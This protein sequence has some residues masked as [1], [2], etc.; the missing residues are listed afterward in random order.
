MADEVQREIVGD[1][2]FR[3]RDVNEAVAK[4]REFSWSDGAE[5]H[6][7]LS[8]DLDK[9]SAAAFRESVEPVAVAACRAGG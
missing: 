1:D 2:R 9:Y 6:Q 4:L 8:T 7:R 5:L 3:F